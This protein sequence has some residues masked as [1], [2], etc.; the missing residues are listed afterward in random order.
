MKTINYKKSS[1]HEVNLLLKL[2]IPLVLTGLIES[3]IGFT[4][5]IFL[6]HLGVHELAAGA[7]VTRIFFTLM[8]VIWGALCS[9]S[10]LVAQKHG[11]KEDKSISD[12][13]RDGLWLGLL[14]MIPAIL[15]L[16]NIAPILLLAG[17]DPTTVKLAEDY[18][19]ALAWG[20]PP[21]FVGLILLQF[22]IGLGHTRTN[23]I[24]TFLWVPL[25]IISNYV[26]I[27]GKWGFPA[28][29]IAGMGWGTTFA[30]WIL[31]FILTAYLLLSRHY[32]RYFRPMLQ[33]SPPRFLIELSKIGF[34]MG[35]MY[36]VELAY[37][38]VLT[39]LMGH[40]GTQILAANQIALQYLM[41][42][43]ALSF[44]MAQAVTVRMGHAIGANDISSAERAG[45]FGIY[46]AV[47][48]M[49]GVAL[50]YWFFPEKL[51]ALD[52]NGE[53]AKELD[54]VRVAKNFLA[55]CAVFQIVE[56]VRIV[57][58]GALRSLKDTRFTLF[59]SIISFWGI[60]LPVGYLLAVPLHLNGAGLWWGMIIGALFSAVLLYLRFQ[61]KIKKYQLSHTV[62][63]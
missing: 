9:V 10:V 56:A 33:W 32:Q 11:A 26:L 59:A 51:I 13:L 53:G 14:L 8:V 18:M 21:D 39:L 12:A 2:T 58:F 47:I 15:L 61:Y 43:G 38:L 49:I 6:A 42:L 40:F 63:I 54:V 25:N 3:S 7:I 60:A 20:I 41:L 29:G 31:V 34:P 35:A 4:S 52:F 45:Y 19:R 17:Q 44:A 55:I 22:L 27:F 5:T 36:F 62:R 46:I 30:Y 16:W 1:I 37:F 48:F 50:C 23:M 28:L 57:L 24:F